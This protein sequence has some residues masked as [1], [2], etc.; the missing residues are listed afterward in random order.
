M[1]FDEW[2]EDTEPLLKGNIKSLLPIGDDLYVI[3]GLAHGG[4]SVGS[5]RV[6]RDYSQPKEPD[7]LVELPDAPSEAYVDQ[8][9]DGLIR[10]TIVGFESLMEFTVGDGLDVIERETFWGGL[11]PTS[12]VKHGDHL[13]IGIRSGVATVSPGTFG[14]R[15]RYFTPR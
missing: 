13:V 12:I 1:Y 7:L 10:I 2:N 6:I 14:R 15:I 9:E 3:E 8:R 4:R 11:Y 5:I